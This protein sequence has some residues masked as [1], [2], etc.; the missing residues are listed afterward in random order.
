HSF[1]HRTLPFLAIGA[2][3]A[4]SISAFAEDSTGPALNAPI[5]VASLPPKPDSKKYDLKYKLQRGDVLRYD[6]THS[7]SIKSTIEKT[8]QAAQT[9]TDSVKVWKVTDVLPDGNVEFMSV[10]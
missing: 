6:V 10:V 9:K 3:L 5:R 7:A 4:I 1:P 2:A 8:T